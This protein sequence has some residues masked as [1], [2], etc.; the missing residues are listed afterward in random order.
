M[1]P[2]LLTERF[3]LIFRR[4]IKEMPIC[5]LVIGQN[6]PILKESA[7]DLSASE[8]SVPNGPTNFPIGKDR[9]SA[10]TPS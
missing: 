2:D 10:A 5:A 6:G 4:Q 7:D 3:H 8:V 9:L 1:L